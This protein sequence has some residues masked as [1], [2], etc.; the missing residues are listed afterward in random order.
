MS[1]SET[2][3][4]VL[5]GER[6]TRAVQLGVIDYLNVA[7]VYDW[8]LRRQ[9]AESGL[10]GI[11]TVAGVPAEMN[12]GMIAGTIDISNVSSFAFGMHA[13]EWL[14]VPRLSVAAYGRVE[15]VL[16]FS[17]HDDWRALD[18]AAITLTGHSATSV[19]LVRLLCERRYGIRPNYV[20]VT[21]PDLDRML[22][23]SEAALLIGDRALVEGHLRRSIAERG[24]P[25]VFDLAAEWKAWTGL[26]FVFAVWAARAE[27]ADAI[28]A[29]GVVELLRA[30]KKRGLADLDRLALEA[31]ERLSLPREVCAHYL[32]LLNYDLTERDLEALRLFLTMTVPSFDWADVRVL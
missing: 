2:T 14:L 5:G 23:R 27:Q 29:S 17:W 28:R 8:L 26:P 9:R 12:R 32:R 30:S 19:E 16:L 13:R 25:F 31:S 24:K 20:T 6:E 18:G 4:H 15:S 11:E 22:E 21:P 1:I 10:P 7:P 3:P